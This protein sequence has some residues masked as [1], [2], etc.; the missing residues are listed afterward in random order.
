MTRKEFLKLLLITV[1]GM[2]MPLSAKQQRKKAPSLFVGH[3]SP[4]NAI[5]N[6]SFT[7]ALHKL[8]NTLQAP[9][10]ILVIS[11]HWY[12]KGSFVSVHKSSEL[13]YDMF[14]F[15]DP[16]YEIEYPAPNAS[17]L[18]SD[19][20][21]IDSDL[22]VQTRALDHG[23][24]SVLLHLFPKA[25]IPVMQLSINNTF[26]MKEH[27]EMGQR[28]QKLREHGVM[29]LGS[30]N[31]THNLRD[32]SMQKENP[33]IASW[34]LEFDSFVKEAIEKEDYAS[35]MNYEQLHPYGKHAH[36]TSEHFIPLLYVAASKYDDD[37][38]EFVYEGFEHATLS[39]RSWIN[40]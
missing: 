20:A 2:S 40:L 22:Q 17:F 1:G 3:G 18:L 13:M 12:T 11:A 5:E 26:S 4:M 19:L 31:I 27:F 23:A 38:S 9:K 33:E 16:L 7:K 36:P 15:P 6:N 30:G 21:K 10:A 32:R 24:W 28:L 37:I 14:G 25:N 34:A 8:G 35:L 39:M 29:I